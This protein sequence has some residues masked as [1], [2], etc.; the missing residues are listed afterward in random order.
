MLKKMSPWAYSLSVLIFSGLVMHLY[1]LVFAA[2]LSSHSNERL[3]LLVHLFFTDIVNKAEF[4]EYRTKAVVQSRIAPQVFVLTSDEVQMNPKKYALLR[5]GLEDTLSNI[6]GNINAI[7]AQVTTADGVLAEW[8]RGG[9]TGKFTPGESSPELGECF[10]RLAVYFKI[11][12]EAFEFA[13]CVQIPIEEY[14]RSFKMPI[15]FRMFMDGE[16]LFP[17]KF[18]RTNPALPVEPVV[19]IRALPEQYVASVVLGR[20]KSL[21]GL[22]Q[23]SES[24]ASERR[25]QLKMYVS[26]CGIALFFSVLPIIV[27]QSWGKKKA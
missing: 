15:K 2:E 11:P 3:Q 14:S 24:R 12:V 20:E 6:G 26:M 23:I 4:I 21:V 22:L 7:G 27:H 19:T 13:A 9:L 16:Y 25:H 5:Q 18:P 17:Q 10:G 8:R 1:W